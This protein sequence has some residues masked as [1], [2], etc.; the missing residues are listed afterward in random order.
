MEEDIRNLTEI[1]DLCKD[2]IENNDEN[3]SAILDL[4]D[5]KSLKNILER[6]KNEQI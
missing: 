5:L 2:E 3:I 4:E 1:I 6:N